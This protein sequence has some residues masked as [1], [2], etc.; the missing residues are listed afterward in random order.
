MLNFLPEQ[1]SRK[2]WLNPASF[3]PINNHLCNDR[4]MF[5]DSLAKTPGHPPKDDPPEDDPPKDDPPRVSYKDQLREYNPNVSSPHP[6]PVAVVDAKPVFGSE[7][8]DILDAQ[9]RVPILEAVRIS[10]SRLQRESQEERDHRIQQLELHIDHLQQGQG[11]KK[12]CQRAVLCALGAVALL[13]IIATAGTCGSGKCR[14]SRSPEEEPSAVLT[15]TTLPSRS[16]TPAP[17][18]LVWEQVGDDLIG[19]K[20]S[21]QGYGEGGLF[22]SAV[23][24]SRDGS[25]L[26]VGFGEGGQFSYFRARAL[27]IQAHGYLAKLYNCSATDECVEIGSINH[28]GYPWSS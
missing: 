16:P 17:T 18:R 22:G 23:S 21:P 5:Q 20:V 1:S 28:P 19:V 14:R 24:F 12:K 6:V 7:E 27:G 2:G 15:S 3:V 13:G 11:A 26:A 4:P 9:S 25:I 10:P 8:D